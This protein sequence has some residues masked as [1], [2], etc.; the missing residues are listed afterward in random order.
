MTLA[1]FLAK[2]GARLLKTAV[3]PWQQDLKEPG[4]L[5]RGPS[6]ERWM[7]IEIVQQCSPKAPWASVDK[8][9]SV[10]VVYPDPRPKQRREVLLCGPA[11]GGM[12]GTTPPKT[13]T[14]AEVP[15]GARLV[16]G[17]KFVEY[18]VD[19]IVDWSARTQC[20]PVP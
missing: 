14:V 4:A 18:P 19:V 10:A 15:E 8:D 5:I 6:G 2:R 1:A 13:M 3:L 16:Q 17:G 20:V 12:C 9:G 11:F 7:V